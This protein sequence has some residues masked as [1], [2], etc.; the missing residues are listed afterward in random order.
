MLELS[1]LGAGLFRD[2]AE[3]NFDKN[4][5]LGQYPLQ[6][7]PLPTINE[8]SAGSTIQSNATIPN[9]ISHAPRIKNIQKLSSLVFLTFS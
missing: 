8:Y 7:L 5:P 2:M 6:K 9:F 1:S 4:E 3:R